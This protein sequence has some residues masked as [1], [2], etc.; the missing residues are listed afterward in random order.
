MRIQKKS[1]EEKQKEQGLKVLTLDQM[2]SRLPITLAQLKTESEN[3]KIL[4]M[5]QDNY[6]NQK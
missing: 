2:L 4:K 6:C 1:G 5:K 3:Q